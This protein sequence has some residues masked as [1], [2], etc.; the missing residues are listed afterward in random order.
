MLLWLQAVSNGNGQVPEA[1]VLGMSLAKLRSE[2]LVAHVFDGLEAGRGGWI[3]TAN[4]DFLRRYTRDPEIR[5]LYD[6][7]DLR[8][9]DGMPL[10]WASRLQNDP[11][12]ER[13]PGSSLVWHLSER[14]ARTGRSIYLLGGT[15]AV[16][17]A[18]ERTLTERYRALRIV[19]RS[20]PWVAPRPTPGEVEAIGRDVGAAR[21]DLVFVGLGSPKQEF[22]I[23]A[24]APR[25]PTTWWMGVGISFS[26]VSG[27]LSR[28]P[29]WV[30]RAG[31]E[32]VHRLAQEP[33]R[34]AYRY[35]VDDAP[36]GLEL[37]SRALVRR[38]RGQ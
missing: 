23:R 6:A 32:W 20:S 24:L 31:L 25:L 12:P 17:R 8:V 35:L 7:A 27:E 29:L 21:P 19:G 14:A 28:A 2:A 33:R 30:Q 4:L 3:V 1:V 13:V 10:V 26:F 22:L 38:A 16:T 9:A 36:F 18:A 5:A 34:L 11:V 37:L 15:E